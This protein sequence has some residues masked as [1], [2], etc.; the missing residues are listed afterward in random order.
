MVGENESK[1]GKMKIIQVVGAR[2]NFMK[3]APVHRALLSYEQ[4]KSL[5]VHTG[6]HSDA[7]MSDV[8]FT[9]LDLPKPDFF[10]G[11]QPGSHTQMTAQIMMA[12]EQVLI[13]ERPDMVLVVGDV[14]STFAC[15][16]TSVRIGIPVAHIEAGLR[17]RDKEMPE[18]INRILTDQISDLLFTTEESAAVNL[19]AEGIEER[20]IHFVGNCMIDSLVDYLPKARQSIW[21]KFSPLYGPRY[22]LMTMHR[23]SNVD[24]KDG[25]LRMIRL[26]QNATQLVPIVFPIH[27]RTK[28]RLSEFGLTEQLLN[29]QKLVVCEPQAYLD[30][31]SLM[32]SAA[33]V[34]TDSGGIQEETT[35]LRIPCLTFRKTTERPVTVDLGT[36]ILIED[37]DP[38]RVTSTLGK[39]LNSNSDSGSIP[40]L[41]D[42]NAAVRIA[43]ILSNSFKN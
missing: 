40:A 19:K 25:L 23:P 5:I 41:W 35:Y 12:F 27:P 28:K 14:N 9:Q 8:F 38:E 29:L 1:E 21:E 13:Q 39:V 31:L 15:A 3:V 24:T 32:K 34:L 20:K 42:G 22:G 17:S 4:V 11:V 7:N 16:L 37:L 2:P 18:E 30:F 6:Q 26:I 43:E 33:V 10:L 36:N